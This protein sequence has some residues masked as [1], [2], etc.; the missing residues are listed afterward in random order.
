MK[1]NL[2]IKLSITLNVKQKYHKLSVNYLKNFIIFFRVVIK[3]VTNISYCGQ[4][5]FYYYY[6]H[7]TSINRIN[8][9]YYRYIM[10]RNLIYDQRQQNYYL[11][12]DKN[13]IFIFKI[14]VIR[15]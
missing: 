7:N 8:M 5:F 15:Y 1:F 9:H 14:V 10:L 3:S 13:T 11:Q 4:T 2:Q 12:H 6:L